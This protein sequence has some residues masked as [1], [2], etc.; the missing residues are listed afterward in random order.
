MIVAHDMTRF[1]WL[2]LTGLRDRGLG[3]AVVVVVAQTAP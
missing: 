2:I 3:D 1:G